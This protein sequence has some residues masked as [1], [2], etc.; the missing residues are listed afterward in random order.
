MFPAAKSTH[1]S[2]HKLVGQIDLR[3]AAGALLLALTVWF[4]WLTIDSLA[5]RRSLRIDLAE[6]SHVRYGLLNAGRWE[7]LIMPILDAR[8]DTFDLRSPNRASL[9]PIIED[10]LYRLL[11]DVKQKMSS[12]NLQGAPAT[13]L[14]GAGNPL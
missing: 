6:I 1:S 7:E 4:T 10:G 5:S 14:P 8:I 9:R 3:L 13:G 2:P 11:D 12:K